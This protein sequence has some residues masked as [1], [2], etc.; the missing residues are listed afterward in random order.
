[1]SYTPLSF[2]YIH[3][4]GALPGL[5]MRVSQVTDERP[6]SHTSRLTTSHP[7]S[8]KPYAPESSLIC[9]D[10]AARIF[11]ISII[12]RL[13]LGAISSSCADAI[14]RKNSIV[15]RRHKPAASDLSQ[16]KIDLPVLAFR[17]LFRG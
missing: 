11:G 16:P 13:P 7:A 10:I 4:L 3:I 9:R 17:I 2:M 14:R 6:L 8:G 15:S 5:S 1:M 12:S